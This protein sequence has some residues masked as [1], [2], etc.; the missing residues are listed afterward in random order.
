MIRCWFPDFYTE[1]H[2]REAEQQHL[3]DLLRGHNI[4]CVRVPEYVDVVF[5]GGFINHHKNREELLRSKEHG[6]PVIHYCW[7]LYPWQLSG[8]PEAFMTVWWKEYVEDLKWATEVWV[9]SSPVTKRVEEFTGRSA[10]VVKCSVRPWEP[11]DPSHLRDGGYVVNVM[12]KYTQDPNCELV[13]D[14]CQRLGIS[15]KE[16][17]CNE[18]WSKFKEII[19]G[20]R[21]LISPYYEA[22]TGGL[23]LLEGYWHGKPVLLSNSPMM[24]ASEYFA[25]QKCGGFSYDTNAHYFRWDDPDNFA[26]RLSF[27]FHN[28]L[29]H[30]IIGARRWITENYSEEA[31]AKRVA[32]QIEAVVNKSPGG[33]QC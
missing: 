3:V 8:D 21:L 27:F 31:F 20:A 11:D 10:K 30:G 26:A 23:T 29:P 9:P 22:S 32:D 28:P 15:C 25:L 1:A 4:H 17:A 2:R 12:R 16:T 13:W 24:G 33:G 5:F 14:T 19:A 6:I 18:P 7:D